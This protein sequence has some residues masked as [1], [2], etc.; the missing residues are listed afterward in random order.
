MVILK[1]SAELLVLIYEFN[2]TGVQ[3]DPRDC[4]IKVLVIFEFHN[5]ISLALFSNYHLHKDPRTMDLHL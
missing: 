5:L 3:Y 2:K 1:P 4:I